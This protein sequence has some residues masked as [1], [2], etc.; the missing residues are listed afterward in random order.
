[1]QMINRVWAWWQQHVD[2]GTFAVLLTILLVFPMLFLAP[3]HGYADNG[4]FWRALYANGIYPF[5]T[6]TPGA[7]TNYVAP[8]YHLMQH[9]NDSRVELYTSQTVFIQLALM[10]NRLFYSREVF[11][12]RFMGIVYFVFF[13]GAIY[14]LTRALAGTKRDIKAYLIALLLVLVFADAGFTLYFNSFY[15]EPSGYIALIY[16]V[17]AW[18]LISRGSHPRLWITVYVISAVVFVTSKQQNYWAALSFLL[19]TLGLLVLP[20]VR[21]HWPYLLL[22]I[23]VISAAGI[24]TFALIPKDR[25]EMTVYQAYTNGVL[26]ETNKPTERT[27]AAGQD[28]QYALM[29]GDLYNPPTTAAISPSDAEVKK[30]LHKKLNLGWI[31][32]YYLKHPD[33]GITLLDGMARSQMLVRPDLIG[34][35]AK[36]RGIKPR[37]Q[38]RYNT[39]VTMMGRT[40]YP[41]RYMFGIA[42]AVTLM[43][44]FVVGAVADVKAGVTDGPMRYV[45]V[46]G[47]LS[48][49]VLTPI[50]ALIDNG[51]TDL[52]RRL[53]NVPVAIYLLI[54]IFTADALSGRLWHSETG[55]EADD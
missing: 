45:L 22:G 27:A 19:I 44:V 21:R 34:N 50:L 46:L 42:L 23:T 28:G 37:Q 7:H 47:L 8:S 20:N 2:P 29:R 1:M 11:D 32:G 6:A 38:L 40:F 53:F 26:M 41:K 36:A 49:V 52:A 31:M 55:G 18:L 16:A 39:L 15:A 9:F 48:I 35:Y 4:D 43:I 14:L 10:L 33:Q 13:L 3:I 25:Q 51:M 5:A 54:M 12:I 24:M 30:H 17:A